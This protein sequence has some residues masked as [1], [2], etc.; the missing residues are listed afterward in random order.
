MNDQAMTREEFER[1]LYSATNIV[2]HAL[3]VYDALREE[4]TR[5]TDILQYI[6]DCEPDGRRY[7]DEAKALATDYGKEQAQEREDLRKEL[8]QAKATRWQIIQDFIHGRDKRCLICGAK[9]PC[10]LKDD[11]ASPCTFEMTP[12]ELHQAHK[13]LAIDFRAAKKRIAELEEL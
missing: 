3:V 4:L 1:M 5:L 8:G 12:M 13:R 6:N 11:P 10:E 2:P 7:L 9:E